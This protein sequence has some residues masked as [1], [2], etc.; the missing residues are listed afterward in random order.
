MLWLH[1]R[2][3]AQLLR[4]AAC[5]HTNQSRSY[6]NHLVYTTCELHVPSYVDEVLLNFPLFLLLKLNFFSQRCEQYHCLLTPWSG[7]FLTN[8]I[9]FGLVIKF[10]SFYGTRTFITAFTSAR[11]LSLKRASSIQ[12]IPPLHTS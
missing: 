2:K 3:V 12:S 4:S 1:S 5:L 6:L 7:V 11:H 8:L 9:G 10:S